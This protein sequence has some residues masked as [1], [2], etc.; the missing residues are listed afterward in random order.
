MKKNNIFLILILVLSFSGCEMFTKLQPVTSS[1]SSSS[2]IDFSTIVCVATSSNNGDDVSGDGSISKPYLT[3]QKALSSL[4]GT[5]TEIRV[6][7]GTYILTSTISIASKS[8]ITI[9]GGYSPSDFTTLSGTAIVNGNGSYQVFNLSSCTNVVLNNLTISNGSAADGA[10]VYIINGSG[11]KIQNCT[12]SGNTATNLGGGIYLS[13]AEGTIITATT[14]ISGNSA[15]VG[16]GIYM[17]ESTNTEIYCTIGGSSSSSNTATQGAGI[18]MDNNCDGLKLNAAIT[19]NIATNQGGG[20]YLDTTTGTISIKGNIDNNSGTNG[21]GININGGSDTINIEA[22]IS[23]N[24]V[25]TEGGGICIYNATPTAINIKSSTIKNNKTTSASGFGGGISITGSGNVTIES[26]VNIS[27]N[28]SGNSTTA[29]KGGGIYLKNSSTVKIYANIDN[30]YAKTQGGGVY[31]SNI[32]T[33]L[34]INAIVTNNTTPGQ[35]GAIEFDGV[36]GGTLATPM[37]IKGTFSGNSATNTTNGGSGGAFNINS[38]GYMTIEAIITGNHAYE[39]AYGGGGI[40]IWANSIGY[41]TIKNSTISSNESAS[42]GG[43]IW[44]GGTS[45]LGTKNVTIESTT[46]INNNIAGSNGGGIFIDQYSSNNTINAKILYN[47]AKGN[48]TTAGG[49]GIYVCGDINTINADIEYNSATYGYGGGIYIAATAE[50]NTIAGTI[51]S[52]YISAT[53]KGAGIY[54]LN[55]YNTIGSSTTTTNIKS[56][57]A[58]GTSTTALG[59]AIY[60]DS[61]STGNL[62]IQYVTFLDNKDYNTITNSTIYFYSYLSNGSLTITNNTFYKRTDVDIS[63]TVPDILI[64][65]SSNTNLTSTGWTNYSFSNNKFEQNTYTNEYYYLAENISSIGNSNPGDLNTGTMTGA[66][67]TSSGNTIF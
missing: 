41:I 34:E 31:I 45:S 19:Y 30:N 26:T 24:T 54:I 8:D 59:G 1:D 35:G 21:G 37:S 61:S 6:A 63:D 14:T 53:G 22:S 56:N 23:N 40:C 43:G 49:G 13:S 52:N 64:L 28:V 50:Q 67:G 3:I 10:G 20:L 38:Y 11:N 29:G 48:T 17:L 4:T 2:L 32:N 36:S 58:A 51:S 46:T 65:F 47:T 57:Y 60:I 18:Y 27:N 44:I 25:T 33:S 15:G 9:N 7:S 12:I 62:V 55:A 16:G 39:T 66:A 42:D 5:K